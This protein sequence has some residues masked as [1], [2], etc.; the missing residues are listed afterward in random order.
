MKKLNF[1]TPAKEPEP[2][3]SERTENQLLK[4][5]A[6]L[7]AAPGQAIGTAGQ[8]AGKLMDYLVSL[9]HSLY[10]LALVAVVYAVIV[11]ACHQMHP[12]GAPY[13]IASGRH[14]L[15]PF[16]QWILDWEEKFHII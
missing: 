7:L 9:L 3:T 10:T 5:L 15:L 8:V 6:S 11:W 13:L 12:V 4:G 1:W 16:G 14:Y 2:K